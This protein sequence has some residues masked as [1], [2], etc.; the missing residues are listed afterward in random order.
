MK[1]KFTILLCAICIIFSVQT[2]TGQIFGNDPEIK[3][4]GLAPESV[5]QITEMA[6]NDNS[7]PIGQLNI[8]EGILMSDWIEWTAIAIKNHARLYFKYESPTL[9]LKIADRQYQSE[10]GWAEAVGNLSKKNYKLYVQDVADRITAISKD[11]G[12][13]QTAVKTSKLIP[14]FSAVF[15]V[16]DLVFKLLKTGK[17][18]NQHLTIEYSVQNNSKKE[19]NV[20]IPLTGLK[21][22]ITSKQTGERGKVVWS[23]PAEMGRNAVIQPDETLSLT[24]EYAINWELNTLPQLDIRV[25]CN[26]GATKDIR[27]MSTYNI[28]LPYTYQEGN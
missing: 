9:I 26:G 13:T 7:I 11:A 17:N 18:E 6:M 3:I 24:I 5:W 10:K 27:Y 22:T 4:D 1:N 14:A 21:K 12:L 28:P 8:D 2:A 23:R 19:I 20:D 15:M 16:D 25:N